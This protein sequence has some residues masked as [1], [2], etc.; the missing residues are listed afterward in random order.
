MSTRPL[1]HHLRAGV[2]CCRARPCLCPQ[3][4]P[5]KGP[6]IPGAGLAVYRPT[7]KSGGSRGVVVGGCPALG[8]H[9]ASQLGE[10]DP[11]A[12]PAN[13]HLSSTSLCL[14]Q[15]S[16]LLEPP[17]FFFNLFGCTGSQL[18]HAGYLLPQAGPSVVA[19][20]LQLPDQASNLCSPALEACSLNHWTT[21]EVPGPLFLPATSESP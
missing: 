20:E 18:W 15:W 6:L 19:C 12:A 10:N 2:M 1:G 17:P 11:R 8:A 21:R 14:L 13:C 7:Q 5:H 9:A 3:P 16:L 4:R